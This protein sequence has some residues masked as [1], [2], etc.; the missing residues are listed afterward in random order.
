MKHLLLALSLLFVVE[1]AQ[2]QVKY[3]VFFTDK[4]NAEAA[5]SNPQN[6]LSD[7]AISRRQK[8][9]IA[10][11]ASDVPV[12]AN[13][14]NA[15]QSQ[16]LMILTTS[17][18]LNAAS[19]F[20]TKAQIDEIA[21]LPFVSEIKPVLQLQTQRFEEMLPIRSGQNILAA[22][23]YA[24]GN[25]YNQMAMLGGNLLHDNDLRGQNMLIAVIDGGF[26]N[27]ETISALD[28]LWQ[29][30]NVIATWDYN[31]GDTN[32][33]ER[34]SHGTNVL[35]VMAGLVDGQLIG[36]APKAQYVLLQTENQGSETTV[37][38]DNWVKA[39]EF[40]D[41]IGVDIINS[42]LGYTTFDQ[43]IGDYTFADLDGRTATTTKAA[44]W[45]ARKG[46]LVVIS[47]GNEGANQWRHISTPADADSILAVGGVDELGNRVGF[48][49][50]GPTADGRIKPDVC[51][52]AKS[53][54]MASS[55][56]GLTSGNGTSFSAPLVAGLAACLWQNHPTKT[57]MQVRNAIIE[58]SSQFYTP[59]TLLGYGIPNFSVADFWL[60]YLD[61]P[62]N[63]SVTPIVQLVPNPIDENLVLHTNL[64]SYPQQ[65][66]IIVTDNIGRE[67]SRKTI[68][69]ENNSVYLP[70]Y[71]ALKSGFYN[72]NVVIGLNEYA[73][74]MIR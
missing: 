3:W 32:V 71:Y 45:A 50:Q 7:R 48:S 37:E 73:F 61:T 53:V 47:A 65:V 40:A 52:K 2:A 14:L 38:E 21:K 66:E 36:S 10:I 26:D 34:G 67:I 12:Y 63:P 68:L 6:Y 9:N 74:R 35:S 13:Y 16:G 5:L 43:G 57:A 8:Q 30:S 17:K 51:A 31:D 33:F 62:E 19:V 56:G 64:A 39:A 11:S 49:S 55:L 42:S 44:A 18:W 25:S 4:P 27:A 46:I 1:F 54:T 24:Y 22:Q 72:F 60:T 70:E 29:N 20:A 15:L 69:L 23:P 58:S 59:D 28:S 41:S